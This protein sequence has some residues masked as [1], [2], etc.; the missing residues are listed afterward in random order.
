MPAQSL[1][2]TI[3]ELTGN[4]VD[5]FDLIEVLTLVADAC[6]ACCESSAAN[7]LL[8]D[9]HGALHLA[10]ASE[11]SGSLEALPVRRAGG[12]GAESFNRNE[13]IT[14]HNLTEESHR[15]WSDFVVAAVRA[16]FRSVHARP[17][18]IGGRPVGSL[19]L[20]G[21]SEGQTSEM[22]LEAAEVLANVA[23]LALLIHNAKERAEF[24]SN[25]DR[26]L[27]D[28]AVIE[29]A[30]GILAGATAQDLGWLDDVLRT[31]A[32]KTDAR[33]ADVARRVV[34][35]SLEFLELDRIAG[36]P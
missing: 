24:R 21:E 14:S 27:E 19:E 25:L 16:G 36:L 5:D 32:R 18:R 20:L 7:L 23:V 4:L 33:L 29:Q 8:A 34:D 2:P 26:A 6:I 3:A 10:A 1:A 30:K 12:P 11:S 15:E 9:R 13:V 22:D 17:L 31:Y 35:G 28:R